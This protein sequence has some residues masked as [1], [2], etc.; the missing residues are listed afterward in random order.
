MT[1]GTFFLPGPTEVR[2]DVLR[3]ML[4]PMVSHRGAEFEALFMRTQEDCSK[5][6]ARGVL[7]ISVRRRQLDSWKLEFVVHHQ[8]IFC[9]SSTAPS[10][11]G[12]RNI[13]SACGRDTERYD[14]AMG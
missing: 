12:S 3:A 6:S 9:R 11:N 1:F 7:S 10:P 4:K 8:G 2:D 5:C 14:V 13:A